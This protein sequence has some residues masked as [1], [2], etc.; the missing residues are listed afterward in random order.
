M[1]E[2]VLSRSVG[3]RRLAS[4]AAAV[5]VLVA[6]EVYAGYNQTFDYSTFLIGVVTPLASGCILFSRRCDRFL[7]FA[8]LGYF[9][10]VVEDAPVYFDSVLTWPEVTRFHPILPHLTL[11]VIVHLAT[12]GFMFL[13][14]REVSGGKIKPGR[15]A[16]W[17][18]L[19]LT[20]AFILAYAQNIPLGA[21]QSIVE[22]SWYQLDVFEH[23]GSVVVFGLALVEAWNFRVSLG[24]QPSARLH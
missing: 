21:V 11:E 9:W 18:Y 15:R 24:A 4:A 16:L 6:T 3:L 17:I 7:L 23:L 20:F 8:F 22:S 2:R 13:S 1:K 12:F 14:V 5:A 10:S 19:L